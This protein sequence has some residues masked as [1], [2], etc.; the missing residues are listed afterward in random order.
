MKQKPQRN[1]F[2]FSKS[3]L[4]I[5]AFACLGGTCCIPT[6]YAEP[7]QAVAPAEAGPVT[8]VVVDSEGE[9]LIGATVLVKGSS[10]GTATDI[11]GRFT[12]KAAPG[13]EL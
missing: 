5:A 13:Q 7:L 6:A 10:T 4:K 8:G 3:L 2:I 9:P 1:S 12:V 11:E